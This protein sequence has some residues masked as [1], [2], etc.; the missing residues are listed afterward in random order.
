MH[1]AFLRRADQS[2]LNFD[3][4]AE[5]AAVVTRSDRLFD[6]ADRRAHA[7]AP[8]LVDDGSARGLTGGFFCGFRIRHTSYSPYV[9]DTTDCERAGL[10]GGRCITVNGAGPACMAGAGGGSD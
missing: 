6:L 5:R 9:L 3:H 7:G 2:R 10:I 4:G 1:D 8:G